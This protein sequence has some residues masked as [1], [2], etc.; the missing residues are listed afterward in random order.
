MANLP[1]PNPPFVRVR[2]D[3]SFDYGPGTRVPALAKNGVGNVAYPQLIDPWTG[4][5]I[6][7]INV[8]SNVAPNNADGL[9]DGTIWLQT[10]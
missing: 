9:P 6:P 4:Q 1:L 5:L 3:G 2:H 10:V 7:I 8:V